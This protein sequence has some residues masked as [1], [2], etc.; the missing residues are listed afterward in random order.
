MFEKNDTLDKVGCT[1][2]NCTYHGQDDMC[3]ASGIK[4][5]AEKVN[6]DTQAETFCQTFQAEQ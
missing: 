2:K 5:E 6:C 3:H 1:V 4:V